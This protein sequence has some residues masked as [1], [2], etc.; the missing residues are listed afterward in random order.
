[1]FE[2]KKIKK[3]S[4]ANI[5]ALLYGLFGFIISFATLICALVKVILEKNIT[6]QLAKFIFM[7]LGLDFLLSL[8]A[9]IIAG[10]IGWFIG[11]IASGFYNF[12]A[13]NIGG[14]KI[15]LS[16]ETGIA[17]AVGMEEKKQKLFKY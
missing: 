10:V 14:V 6:D 16:D 2:V 13:K 11:L 12:L 7:N 1:M 3:L 8:A 9:A 15:E 4:L 5:A 17:P